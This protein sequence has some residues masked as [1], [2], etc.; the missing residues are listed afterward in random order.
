MYNHPIYKAQRLNL[1]TLSIRQDPDEPFAY[2]GFD[3]RI[4]FLYA[5]TV[6][7]ARIL[8]DFVT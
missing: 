1:C 5:R 2:S 3:A 8:K 7:E 6:P 4:L